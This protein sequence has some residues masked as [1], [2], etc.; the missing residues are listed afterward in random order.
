[1]SKIESGG[2]KSRQEDGY[3]ASL[4]T[5]LFSINSKLTDMDRSLSY[6]KFF[7]NRHKSCAKSPTTR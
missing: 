1:M 4:W 2:K 5:E 7:Q 3:Y 6:A